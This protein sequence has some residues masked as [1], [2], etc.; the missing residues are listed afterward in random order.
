LCEVPTTE[1]VLDVKPR[2]FAD[3]LHAQ[4]IFLDFLLH[5]LVALDVLAPVVNI[6]LLISALVLVLE[7]KHMS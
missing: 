2:V 6:C 4:A 3:A 5:F 1:L 7:S